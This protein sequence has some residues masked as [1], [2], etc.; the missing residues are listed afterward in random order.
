MN[1]VSVNAVNIVVKMPIAWVT[2]KPRTGPGADAE[3][4]DGGDERSDVRIENCRERHLESGLDRIERRAAIAPFLADALIDQHIGIDRHA[5]GEHD[6][7][8]ARQRQRE[9]DHRHDGDQHHQIGDQRHIG[10]TC[11][12]C[13]K[14][15]P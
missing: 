5:H 4:H 10:E 7:G 2:A 15:R 3:E 13:H 1:R 8:D 9:A 12:I 6:A 11:R 14:R